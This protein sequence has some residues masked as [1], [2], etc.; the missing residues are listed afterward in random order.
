MRFFFMLIPLVAGELLPIADDT[1]PHIT[2]VNAKSMPVIWNKGYV[3]QRLAAS[4]AIRVNGRGVKFMS[5]RHSK[6][7]IP[8]SWTKVDCYPDTQSLCIIK[9]GNVSSRVFPVP[10]ETVYSL[11]DTW[12]DSQRMRQII[13]IH[14]PESD[15]K[16]TIS[17]DMRDVSLCDVIGGQ[18]DFVYDIANQTMYV[19]RDTLDTLFTAL[20]C[21]AVIYTAILLSKN[22]DVVLKAK[23]TNPERTWMAKL[24]PL[25][26]TLIVLFII[27][28][29]TIVSNTSSDLFHSIITRED[30]V[31]FAVTVVFS[32]VRILWMLEG[33]KQI[34]NY[35]Y[36]VNP[37]ICIL[38][39][40]SIR[41]YSTADNP[42]AVALTAIFF[43][44]WT[45]K[46]YNASCSDDM[47]NCP[48]IMD[49]SIIL[50]LLLYYSVA[51]FYDHT[52]VNVALYAI[53]C[54]AVGISI[55]MII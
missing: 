4:M 36:I 55:H 3:S 30:R 18:G 40:I 52:L 31:I 23:N 33:S 26:L 46:I 49:D 21:V 10:P 42:Y 17:D 14:C 53:Q 29:P 50:A 20:T 44:R 12:E 39:L 16:R 51:P 11:M 15:S 54:W 48:H 1:Y 19:S 2:F 35:N 25:L 37:L 13:P 8:D 47:G 6:L 28:L 43:I 34:N 45:M 24:T 7:W 5:G 9:Q 27:L 32:S 41:F 38:V 22:L